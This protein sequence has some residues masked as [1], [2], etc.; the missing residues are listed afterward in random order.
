MRTDRQS[1]RKSKTIREETKTVPGDMKGVIFKC[2]P[3]REE[4]GSLSE[5][6]SC[7]KIINYKLGSVST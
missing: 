1:S 6:R 2:F 7:L 3:R 5:S 4:L